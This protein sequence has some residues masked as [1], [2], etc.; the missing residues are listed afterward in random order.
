MGVHGREMHAVW[1]MARIWMNRKEGNYSEILCEVRMRRL[2]GKW[3]DQ[4][5]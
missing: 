4:L 3:R 5:K 2:S 1:K